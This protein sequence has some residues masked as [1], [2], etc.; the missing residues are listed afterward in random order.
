MQI[1]SGLPTIKEKIHEVQINY[2]AEKIRTDDTKFIEGTQWEKKINKNLETYNI[3][4][5]ELETLDKNRVANLIQKKINIK[6]I[7][8]LKIKGTTATKTKE[9]SKNINTDGL[10]ILPPA[11]ITKLPRHLAGI[12]FKTRSYM[13]KIRK[14]MKTTNPDLSCRWCKQYQETQEHIIT[15]CTMTP[16][17]D[18]DLNKAMTNHN[19]TLIKEATQLTQ[20]VNLL[21]KPPDTDT[22]IRP[23]DTDIPTRPPDTDIPNRPINNNPPDPGEPPDRNIPN[24][25]LDIDTPNRLSDSDQ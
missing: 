10:N 25:P 23:P 21:D 9:M 5:E 7:A 22:P 6:R 2:Y 1:Q 20:I 13:L 3:K 24:R 16:D 19:D 17:I 18:I 11:Y 4:K 15:E 8:S 12:I 14:N